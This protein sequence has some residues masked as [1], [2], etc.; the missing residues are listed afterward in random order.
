MSSPWCQESQKVKLSCAR[1]ANKTVQF[2]MPEEPIGL[3]FLSHAS[4]RSE[5]PIRLTS[6]CPVHDVKGAN[7]VDF[8]VL[9]EQMRLT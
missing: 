6:L 1:I 7:K 8:P 4:H 3:T 5:E 9:E 2:P